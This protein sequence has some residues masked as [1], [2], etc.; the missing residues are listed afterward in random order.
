MTCSLPHARS[1]SPSNR[2]EWWPGPQA[3]DAINAAFSKSAL[4]A[5]GWTLTHVPKANIGTWLANLSPTNTGILYLPTVNESFGDLAD[6]DLAVVNGFGL[7]I[8]NFV[9]GGG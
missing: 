4:P 3:Q 2:T 8:E 6:A 5:A 7:Q 1:P 9:A